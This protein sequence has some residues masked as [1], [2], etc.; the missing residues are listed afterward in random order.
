MERGAH[1]EGAILDEYRV[2]DDDGSTIAVSSTIRSY[3]APAD[4]W[5]LISMDVGGG[6]LDFGTA[7]RV[8]GEM[9]IEQKFTVA[10]DRR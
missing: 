1:G 8:A 6:L 4:R 7:Q 2:L 3:N 10:E 5:E 9:H